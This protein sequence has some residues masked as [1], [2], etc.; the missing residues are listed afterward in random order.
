MTASPKFDTIAKIAKADAFEFVAAATD[1]CEICGALM[2]HLT[3]P[4]T[5]QDT[6]EC[7]ACEWSP[8]DAW[9]IR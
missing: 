1:R 7:T 3:G 5:W 2:V 4:A 9:R 6:T 8:D